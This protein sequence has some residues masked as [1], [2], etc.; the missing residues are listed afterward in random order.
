MNFET[1]SKQRKMILIAAAV[2]VISLFLPWVSIIGFSANGLHGYGFLV[3]LCFIAAGV[4]AY[5]GDQTK[6]LNQTNWMGVLIAGGVAILCMAID[7]L[8]HL[9]LLRL[10]SFGFYLSLAAALAIVAFAYMHRSASDSLQG[11]FDSLKHRINTEMGSKE[12]ETKSN[13]TVIN[14]TSND[15][16]KPVV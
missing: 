15:P 14:P 7:L 12:T 10:Y 3:F 4:L 16:S 13:T 8:T 11:G 2:G 6:N 9:D 5:T 1:M